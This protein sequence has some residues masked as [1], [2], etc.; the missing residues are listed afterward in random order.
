L[1]TL[2]VCS[3]CS[4]SFFF[5]FNDGG[6]IFLGIRGSEVGRPSDSATRVID[7]VL[8]ASWEHSLEGCSHLLDGVLTRIL[9][10][11][12][13]DVGRAAASGAREDYDFGDD[14]HEVWST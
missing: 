9:E 4:R 1:V 14:G 8:D 12:R 6:N 10:I 13:D 3:G 11:D 7:R 2:A 5:S